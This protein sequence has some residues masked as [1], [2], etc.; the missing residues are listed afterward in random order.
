M[1]PQLASAESVAHLFKNSQL[2]S[3]PA[4]L[5]PVSDFLADELLQTVGLKDDT[6]HTH[7]QPLASSDQSMTVQYA[8]PPES[9]LTQL[10]STEAPSVNR[11]RGRT[12]QPIPLDVKRLSA[13]MRSTETLEAVLPEGFHVEKVRTLDADHT[14]LR[15]TARISAVVA[16]REFLILQTI[17]AVQKGAVVVSLQSL[18][19]PEYDDLPADAPKPSHVRGK[20]WQSGYV[21]EPCNDP[22]QSHLHFALQ[23]DAAGWLPR[24][25]TQWIMAFGLKEGIKSSDAKQ[26]QQ[27]HKPIDA[28]KSAIGVQQHH[29][30]DKTSD[31]DAQ[32][33]ASAGAISKGPQVQ[34]AQ[35]DAAQVRV[36]QLDA[37]FQ[38][39]SVLIDQSTSL[40]LE[41][42]VAQELQRRIRLLQGHVHSLGQVAKH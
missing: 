25:A 8:K 34:K 38:Q 4:N 3:I 24:S 27:L 11:Y 29:Q 10:P 41:P 36:Q 14:I 17:R 39:L 30:E 1:Q 21:I 5:D 33:A 6:A 12:V 42:V 22:Q 2:T 32:S 19:L 31:A 7:W 18:T 15:L 23:I 28:V 40:V 20:M 9:Q 13:L 26:Q 16:V 35:F 37:E